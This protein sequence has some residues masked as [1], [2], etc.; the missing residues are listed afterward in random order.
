MIDT[1]APAAIP[2]NTPTPPK[3]K[4]SPSPTPEITRP[5]AISSPTAEKIA[6]PS[7]TPA[8][9]QP[10]AQPDYNRVFSGGEVDQRA[11]ILSK[12]A[13]GYT[14]EARKNQVSGTVTLRVV[15]AASGQVANITVVKGLPDGLSE[16]AIAAARQM[17]FE[18][19]RKD[20]RAVSQSLTIQMNFSL[21]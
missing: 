7:E 17:R 21:Y 4:S 19:A 9:A 13:P 8:I 11:V 1:P 14:E 16:K 20:G 18:P 10:S 12:P 3:G 2:S 5:T 15:L 6:V